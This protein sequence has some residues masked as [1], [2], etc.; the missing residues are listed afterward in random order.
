MDVS[1]ID[2][3]KFFPRQINFQNYSRR[4]SLFAVKNVP[5]SKKGNQALTLR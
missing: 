3:L 5:E 1:P 2:V 4:K